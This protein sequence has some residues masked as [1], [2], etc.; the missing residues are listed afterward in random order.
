MSST[1]S[2]ITKTN[3]KT[4]MFAL[5]E[6]QTGITENIQAPHYLSSLW[7]ESIGDKW[8]FLTKYL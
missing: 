6:V 8:I 4:I 3:S 5:Q 2:L 7:R 1:A